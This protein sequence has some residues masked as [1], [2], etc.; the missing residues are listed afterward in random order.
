MK[1]LGVFLLVLAAAAPAPDNALGLGELPPQVLAKNSCALFLWDRASRQRIVMAVAVP[2]QAMVQHGGKRLALA[3]T[4]GDGEAVLGFRPRAR[5][6]G[7]DVALALDLEITASEGG[8]AVIRTGTVT[9]TMADGGAV[10]APV[11]GLIGCG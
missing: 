10:V 9:R 6:A 4:G 1:R 5:Y 8:G 11:A 3:Q 2:A 7:G